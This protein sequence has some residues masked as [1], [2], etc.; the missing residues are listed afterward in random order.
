MNSINDISE[1]I[2]F[3]ESRGLCYAESDVL[4]LITDPDIILEYSRE[5]NTNLGIIYSSPY[6]TILVDLVE[7]ANGNRFSYE[8]I[9]KTNPGNSVVIV[10]VK[11]NKYVL[12]KHFRHSVGD[13]LLEFPRGYGE[14]QISIEENTQKEVFEEL[15]TNATDIR[16]L[17]KV[18]ADSGI[19]GEEV[20]I[21]ECRVN[22][23]HIDG[24]YEGIREYYL[25]TLEE[26][27]KLILDGKIVDA[28]TLSAVTFLSL[29][30]N[31]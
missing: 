12:L 11:N 25:L 9:I 13:Y 31:N 17:G 19:C 24:V 23:L 18:I 14:P 27:K 3:I 16:V 10:A 28:H 29:E 2:E 15:N 7:D 4:K 1:Y 6:N 22:E 8:R 20:N 30:I 26:I 5:H 21:V